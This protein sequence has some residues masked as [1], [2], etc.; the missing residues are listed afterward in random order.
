MKLSGPQIATQLR[1]N[2]QVNI[3]RHLYAVLGS[4]ACLETFEKETLCQ[5][6]LPGSQLFPPAVNLNRALLNRIG[7]AD[8]REL[9]RSEGKRPQ[10][11]QKR[12]N[13]EF[14]G[15]LAECLQKSPFLALKQIELLFAYKLDLQTVRAR[16]SN[17]NH[18]VLLL[19]GEKRGDHVSLFVEASPRFQ[20]ELPY[21][22]I[23][24]NHL[25][26]LDDVSHA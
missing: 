21:Q 10:M 19:P 9:V 25:W 23:A 17:N 7:D 13:D 20:R 18:I 4:Y 22:L 14:D 12:L 6:P 11:I 16:A 3:G 5:I 26:E 8:L 15:L 1:Q 2:L 24:D